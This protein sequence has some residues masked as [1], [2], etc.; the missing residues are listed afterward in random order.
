MTT[1]YRVQQNWFKTLNEALDAEGLVEYWPLGL[2][3]RYDQTV[4]TAKNGKYISVYRAEN[5]Q[6]ERP[7]H[8]ATKMADTHW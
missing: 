7:I 2:N 5:G 1:R 6:Y 3:V 8:Y 4:S